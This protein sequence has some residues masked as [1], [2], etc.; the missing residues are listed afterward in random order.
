LLAGPILHTNHAV[1][2]LY[3]VIGDCVSSQADQEDAVLSQRGQRDAAI[4]FDTG[5]ILRHRAQISCWSHRLCLQ[6]Q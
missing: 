5:R 1:V 4:N 2:P 6:M 3:Y